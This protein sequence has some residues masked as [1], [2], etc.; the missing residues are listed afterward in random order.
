MPIHQTKFA[1][2]KP[3]AT[4]MLTPQMPMPTE[5]SAVTAT[6]SSVKRPHPARLVVQV[7]E[8]DRL[9]RAG[10]LAGRHDLAVADPAALLLGG[11]PSLHDALHAVRALLHHPAAPHGDVG[12]VEQ[13]QALGVPARVLEE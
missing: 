10:L 13:L 2:A 9:G 1:I 7:A 11:D 8:H 4:G 6:T 5:S 12:I 3:Q